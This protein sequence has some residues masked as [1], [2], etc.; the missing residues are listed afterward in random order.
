M[1]LNLSIWCCRFISTSPNYLSSLFFVCK[2]SKDAKLLCVI[3]FATDTL[4]YHCFKKSNISKDIFF[5]WCWFNA[6]SL[7]W[8]EHQPLKSNNRFLIYMPSPFTKQICKDILIFLWLYFYSFSK[9]KT[10]TISVASTP[11]D[12]FF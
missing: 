5:N 6:F 11:T 1:S 8:L 12:D 9:T 2:A 4:F 7:R 3:D 10:N